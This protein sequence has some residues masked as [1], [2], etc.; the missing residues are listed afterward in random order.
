VTRL[1]HEWDKVCRSG[2]V[3]W[4]GGSHAVEAVALSIGALSLLEA[5]STDKARSSLEVA[6]D[7]GIPD[8][9]RSPQRA[10]DDRSEYSARTCRL[11]MASDSFGLLRDT[12]RATITV[13]ESFRVGQY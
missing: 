12:V 11:S 7:D 1:L 9:T 10:C 5:G 3:E 13:G 2:G 6:V 8:G 4:G